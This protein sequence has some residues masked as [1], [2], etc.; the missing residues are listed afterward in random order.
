MLHQGRNPF[1]RRAVI[2]NH[3]LTNTCDGALLPGRCASRRFSN[4]PQQMGRNDHPLNLIGALID[5]RNLG[6]TIE[7]FHLHALQEAVATV[8]LQRVGS[9]HQSPE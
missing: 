7:A 1:F 6:I 3:L 8:N 9:G 4:F 5:G 2:E